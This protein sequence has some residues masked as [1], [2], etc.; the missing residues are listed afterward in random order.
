MPTN[1]IIKL[2]CYFWPWIHTYIYI[3]IWGN[4]FGCTAR[5]KQNISDALNGLTSIPLPQIKKK[6]RKKQSL[7]NRTNYN[8][9]TFSTFRT[10]IWTYILMTGNF[11]CSHSIETLKIVIWRET[12][13]T[14]LLRI[15]TSFARTYFIR[16][17]RPLLRYEMYAQ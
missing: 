14:R 15:K 3:Y 4:S 13:H 1:V 11:L 9:I 2:N 8:K 17:L 7:S 6:N 5:T 12:I 16:E 10:F